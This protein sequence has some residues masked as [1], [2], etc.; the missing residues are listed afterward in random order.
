MKSNYFMAQ[1]L[2]KK[3][4]VAFKEAYRRVKIRSYYIQ[5]WIKE[6]END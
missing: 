6:N 5:K 3:K 4:G 1:A 2:A